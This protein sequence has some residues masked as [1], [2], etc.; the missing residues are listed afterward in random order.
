MIQLKSPKII[1][2]LFFLSGTA[3]LIYEIVWSRLLILVFGS[4]TNSIVAVI[5]AFLGGLAIGSLIFGKIADNISSQKLIK[6]YAFLELAIGLT[7][8]LTLILI[9]GVKTVYAN[10][11]DGSSQSLGLIFVK[12]FFSI[13]VLIVPT[14]LMGA[15][16]PI[17]VNF[18]KSQNKKVDQSVSILYAVNTFGA[19]LGVLL[20]AFILI[21][22]LGLA[23]TLFLQLQSTF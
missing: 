18:I 17:L 11:S 13:S 10:F 6:T 20:S 7:A 22:L 2:V 21:E 15:T 5:S 9:P 12:F 23:N 1:Y 14:I 8:A 3:G 4:T 19:V 16:L